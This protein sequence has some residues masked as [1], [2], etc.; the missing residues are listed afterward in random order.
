M[1]LTGFDRSKVIAEARKLFAPIEKSLGPSDYLD[2]DAAMIGSVRLA[3]TTE[4]VLTVPLAERS[5]SIRRLLA[6]EAHDEWLWDI[7]L[8]AFYAI[9]PNEC[10]RGLEAATPYL[11]IITGWSSG[12]MEDAAGAYVRDVEVEVQRPITEPNYLYLSGNQVVHLFCCKV[13]QNQQ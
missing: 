4:G 12:Y 7:P 10:F 9:P 3:G 11:T 1:E 6:I 8:Y 5:L 2:Y 13:S